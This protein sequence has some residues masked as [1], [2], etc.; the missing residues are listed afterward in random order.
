M[1]RKQILSESDRKEL[2]DLPKEEQEFIRYYTLSERDIS[3]IQNNCRGNANKNRI[4]CEF[5]L[6]EVSW[7]YI[8]LNQMPDPILINYKGEQLR[9]LD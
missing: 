6:Y 1:P 8:P 4:R 9:I 5:V 7:N 2:I 3:I